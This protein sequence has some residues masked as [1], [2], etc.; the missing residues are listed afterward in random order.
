MRSLSSERFVSA[1]PANMPDWAHADLEARE[2]ELISDLYR[3]MDRIIPHRKT[4]WLGR[5]LLSFNEPDWQNYTNGVSVK[6]VY[7]A[8]GEEEKDWHTR[9]WLERYY[10]NYEQGIYVVTDRIP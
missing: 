9:A 10:L 1:G 4:N 7:T 2:P 8:T 3:R 6:A 5:M